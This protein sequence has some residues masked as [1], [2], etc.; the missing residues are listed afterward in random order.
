MKT[1]HGGVKKETSMA[2]SISSL[3]KSAIFLFDIHRITARHM[4][5]QL[6]YIYLLPC[7]YV[8][9]SDQVLTNRV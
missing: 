9:P 7:S 5:A 6:V 1:H 3:L 8:W 4:T 2:E